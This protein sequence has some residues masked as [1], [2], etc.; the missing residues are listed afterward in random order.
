[1]DKIRILDGTMLKLLAMV[2]MLIDHVGAMFFPDIPLFRIIGRIAMPIFCFCVAEGFYYT[3]SRRKYLLRL[4]IF[5]LISEIPFDLALYGWFMMDH[6]NVMVTFLVA[7]MAL[8]LYDRIRGSRTSGENKVSK[9]MTAAG[10]AAVVLL[11]IGAE[12]LKTD[13]GAFGVLLVFLFYFMKAQSHYLQQL[14]AFLFMAVTRNVG[15]Y[16]YTMLS[17]IPLVLYNGKKGKGLKWLFYVFYPGHLMI[18]YLIS[19]VFM[20]A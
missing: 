16:A 17:S 18:L 19:K 5:A 4:G 14:T 12:M 8:T 20:R 9:S 11:A 1:M 3:K 15:V 6:Q 2:S 7:G 10:I 13:Y